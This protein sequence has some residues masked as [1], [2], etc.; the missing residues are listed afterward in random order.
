MRTL[1]TRFAILRCFNFLLIVFFPLILSASTTQPAD[2]GRVNTHPGYSVLRIFL[3]DEQYLTAIRHFKSIISF[4]GTAQPVADLVD[5][6]ADISESSLEQLEDLAEEKP[7]IR[8]NQLEEDSVAV[9][10]LDSLRYTTARRFIDDTA[11][12]EKN[13]LLSQVQILP[14]IAHLAQTLQENE[15]NLERKY[16]LH[17]LSLKFTVLYRRATAQLNTTQSNS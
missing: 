12:F 1:S 10:T 17:K 9:S 5:D 4:S 16:W 8:F 6:I 11:N 13:I 14:V 15:T 2:S 7:K 3:E